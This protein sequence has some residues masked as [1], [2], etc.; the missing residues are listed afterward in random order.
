[1]RTG[2]PFVE[3]P[4]RTSDLAIAGLTDRISRT[5]ELSNGIRVA[6]SAIISKPSTD[7]N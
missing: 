5:C 4:R 3:F 7:V 6:R 2:Q 1:M